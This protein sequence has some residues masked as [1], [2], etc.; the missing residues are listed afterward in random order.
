MIGPDGSV[1]ARDLAERLLLRSQICLEQV[2]HDLLL[3]GAFSRSDLVPRVVL[4]NVFQLVI[5]VEL[6]TQSFGVGLLVLVV[7]VQKHVLPR[8]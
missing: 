5:I 1:R 6:A 2:G 8:L 4:M 3:P 7:L